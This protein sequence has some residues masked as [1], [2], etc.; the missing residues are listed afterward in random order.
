MKVI[1]SENDSRHLKFLQNKLSEYDAALLSRINE[2]I[3]KEDILSP[4]IY[5]K[6]LTP[7]SDIKTQ[8]LNDLGRKLIISELE[9]FYAVTMPAGIELDDMGGK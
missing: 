1:Y 7:D 8:F 2:G 4:N 5:S 6:M 3:R 9:K